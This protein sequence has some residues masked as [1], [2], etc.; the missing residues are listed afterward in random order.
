MAAAATGHTGS[1]RSE[2]RSL[3]LAGHWQPDSDLAPIKGPAA[4]ATGSGGVALSASAVARP[5]P[6]IRH[7]HSGGSGVH[8][9]EAATGPR[10]LEPC[11]KQLEVLN[12]NG[13]RT[14]PHQS[15]QMRT[16]RENEQLLH[17]YRQRVTVVNIQLPQ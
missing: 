4:P 3:T 9:D 10:K 16:V 1:L 13:R 14:R 6:H 11:G 2:S 12:L 8:S 17:G 15:R 5:R 7:V